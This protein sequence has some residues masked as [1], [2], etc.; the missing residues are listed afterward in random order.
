MQQSNKE[1]NCL[2]KNLFV[3]E[4]HFRS[5]SRLNL[6][7]IRLCGQNIYLLWKYTTSSK[8]MSSNDTFAIWIQY[9]L[10]Q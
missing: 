4:S 2:V 1:H 3:Q 6:Q 9:S 7:Q 5:E 8:K 10:I